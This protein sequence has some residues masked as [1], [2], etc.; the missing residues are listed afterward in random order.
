MSLGAEVRACL[1]ALPLCVFV[2]PWQCDLV[3]LPR[4][5]GDA[6]PSADNAKQEV[7]VDAV[8]SAS[9]RLPKDGSEAVPSA[10]HAK[11]EA[12]ID[13]VSSARPR[14]PAAKLVTL[15]DAVVVKVIGVGHTAFLRCWGLAQRTDPVL[16]STKVRLHIEIDPSGKVTAVESDS[17]SKTLSNC[18]ARVARQ[19][20][21][22][23]PGTPAVVDLPLIFQ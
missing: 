4:G 23:E 11:R 6:V 10:V 17:D 21:F 18:L 2:L 12:A 9:P 8:S 13:R 7:V 15:P 1:A 16:S 14:T 20:P 22:P 19:L 5:A 3:A